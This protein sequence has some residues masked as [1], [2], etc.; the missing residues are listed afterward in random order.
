VNFQRDLTADH[1][2][3]GRCYLPGVDP[4]RLTEADKHRLLDDVDA[5][6]AAAAPAVRLLPP[7]SRR[8]VAVAHGLFAEL[9]HRLRAAP[10]EQVMAERVRVPGRVKARIVLTRILRESRP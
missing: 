2:R 9:A 6:L 7:G 1:Q 8:A 4:A 5:D 3:R 10:A